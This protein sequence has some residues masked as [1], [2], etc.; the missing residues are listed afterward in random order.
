MTIASPHPPLTQRCSCL[1]HAAASHSGGFHRRNGH[2]CERIKA[3]QSRSCCMVFISSGCMI[4]ISNVHWI[5][6]FWARGS[7][8][9]TIR[10]ARVNGKVCMLLHT[11]DMC[12]ARICYDTGSRMTLPTTP[13]A[14]YQSFKMNG[15]FCLFWWR[16][17]RSRLKRPPPPLRTF[18]S[19]FM[20]EK[21]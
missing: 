16:F 12:C 15:A 2:R 21:L 13:S 18:L 19:I 9:W 1:P 10:R 8:K 7:P 6:R 5:C 3:G 20:L 4:L 17:W 11:L 14:R